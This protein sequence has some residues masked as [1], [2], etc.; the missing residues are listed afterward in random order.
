MTGPTLLIMAAGMGTRYGGLK[1]IDPVGPNGEWII[2][3]SL[4]DAIA[5]GFTRVVFV[6]RRSFEQAFRERMGRKLEGRVET[7]YA[8]Q[9]LDMGL[10]GHPVP[11]GR[12]KPW[13]TAH[14]VLVASDLIDGPFAVINAD[15]YYGPMAYPEILNALQAMASGDGTEQVMVGYLLRNTLSEHGG[16]SRGVCRCDGR[17][18]LMDVTEIHDIRRRGLDAMVLDSAG[19]SQ[20][21]AGDSVVSMNFWGFHPR[22]S[23]YLRGQFE[24]FLRTEAADVHK[25]F[26]LPT[27]VDH[28]MAEGRIRVR[29]LRT[30]DRWFGVTYKQDRDQAA[31]Q[32]NELI[33]QGRYPQRLWERG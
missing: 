21:L 4:Y 8:F 25:E 3:Y 16:V 32:I 27:A 14:A 6:I 2:D 26:Y 13:G 28:L 10:G 33:G 7:A 12:E 11:A 22:I 17:G 5:A 29:V 9:E 1:Q 24:R 23:A 19:T 30:E 15:D 20:H 18:Y 31:A